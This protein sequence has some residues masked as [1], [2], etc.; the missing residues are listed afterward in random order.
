MHDFP[1]KL[2]QNEKQ[3][4]ISSKQGVISFYYKFANENMLSLTK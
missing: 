1:A 3:P 4:N 2:S